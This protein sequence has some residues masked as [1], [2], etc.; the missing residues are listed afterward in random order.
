MDFSFYSDRRYNTFLCKSLLCK[1]LLFTNSNLNNPT[2]RNP[3]SQFHMLAVLYSICRAIFSIIICIVQ[4]LI[5]EISW[6]CCLYTVLYKRS[7]FENLFHK[8]HVFVLDPNPNFFL[9]RI[10]CVRLQVGF[11]NVRNRVTEE[12]TGIARQ[13][14][15]LLCQYLIKNK[16][17]FVNTLQKLKNMKNLLSLNC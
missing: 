2:L 15:F 7:I 1:Y 4:T 8:K 12:S 9:I 5:I 10:L 6:R 17:V 13:P 11:S 16:Y 14:Q 3:Y